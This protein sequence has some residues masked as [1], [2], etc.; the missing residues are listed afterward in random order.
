M[1]FISLITW[2]HLYSTKSI[3]R[4]VSWWF[5]CLAKQMDQ[6]FKL[7]AFFKLWFKNVFS[8]V[9]FLMT[10]RKDLDK[11][12]A[13]QCGGCFL[14]HL[15]SSRTVLRFSCG[16]RTSRFSAFTGDSFLHHFTLFGHLNIFFSLPDR[17]LLIKKNEKIKLLVCIFELLNTPENL[18]S[19]L[20]LDENLK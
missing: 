9:A 10:V 20:L 17:K 12:E 1:L 7:S 5:K 16:S 15:S 8:T 6:L 2:N 3:K 18:K 11:R 14:I 19:T 13:A 4:C